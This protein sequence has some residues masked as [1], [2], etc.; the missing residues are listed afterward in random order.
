[1]LQEKKPICGYIKY[2]YP[3]QIKVSLM[4]LINWVLHGLVHLKNADGRKKINTE[5]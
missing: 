5:F 4:K 2:H 1:M 3:E